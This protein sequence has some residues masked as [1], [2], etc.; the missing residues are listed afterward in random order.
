MA[1]PLS[2]PPPDSAVCLWYML[3][4]IDC[5]IMVRREYREEDRPPN[6]YTIHVEVVCRP[7]A[8]IIPVGRLYLAAFMIGGENGVTC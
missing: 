5:N 3:T 4:A 7:D 6:Y 1:G 2:V 8:T